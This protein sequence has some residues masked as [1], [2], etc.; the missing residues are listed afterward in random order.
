MNR[1]PW[2]AD[3][4]II[5]IANSNGAAFNRYSKSRHTVTETFTG[6][7]HPEGIGVGGDGTVWTGA[8]NEYLGTIESDGASPPTYAK[9]TNTLT[10]AG[11]GV[12]HIVVPDGVTPS[13]GGEVYFSTTGNKIYSTDYAGLATNAKTLVAPGSGV[14]QYPDDIWWNSLT[15][16][17]EG[18][19]Y[20]MRGEA[21]NKKMIKFDPT[22][23]AASRSFV[24]T[25]IVA[26]DTHLSSE[27]HS[28]VAFDTDGKLLTVDYYRGVWIYD[29]GSGD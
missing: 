12:E 26:T 13:D 4:D 15:I 11:G 1:R 10:G 22:L 20:F 18:W 9:G 5:W 29:P 27:T 17:P 8:S 2:E 24:E 7:S 14:G 25:N 28:G 16:G 19:V 23:P 3:D 21:N 6:Y